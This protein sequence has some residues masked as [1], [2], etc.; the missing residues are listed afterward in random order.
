MYPISISNTT[1]TSRPS[2]IFAFICMIILHEE[3]CSPV[4]KIE[5]YSRDV[6]MPTYKFKDS[7]G[8]TW[9]V[10]KWPLS[11]ECHFGDEQRDTAYTY[12]VLETEKGICPTCFKKISVVKVSDEHEDLRQLKGEVNYGTR[13]SVKDRIVNGWLLAAKIPHVVSGDIN[14]APR[15]GKRPGPDGSRPSL[16]MIRSISG[17]TTRPTFELTGPAETSEAISGPWPQASKEGPQMSREETVINQPRGPSPKRNEANLLVSNLIDPNQNTEQG[18]KYPNINIWRQVVKRVRANIESEGES[19]LGVQTS[20]HDVPHEEA[21]KG[22]N[23][24]PNTELNKGPFI[25]GDDNTEP[26]A[27]RPREARKRTILEVYLENPEIFRGMD[28]YSTACLEEM[29]IRY[30]EERELDQK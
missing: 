17:V 11:N 10:I 3:G 24:A 2:H 20:P 6:K 1:Q 15:M 26:P 8:K 9:G 29:L 16:R 7:A 28:D 19:S 23:T 5:I 4:I 21:P 22:L 14:M 25:D 27:K 13:H 12:S 30:M 18:H